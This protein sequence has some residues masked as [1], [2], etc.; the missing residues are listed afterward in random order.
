M[1]RFRG[2]DINN[3]RQQMDD[4]LNDFFGPAPGRKGAS[5]SGEQERSQAM[6]LNVVETDDDVTIV[7]PL[8]G[9]GPECV[10]VSIRGQ[11]V[12]IRGRRSDVFPDGTHYYRREWG[13]GPFHR[14]FELP[15]PIDPE[16]SQATVHRGVLRLTIAK[17]S[18]APAV[19]ASVEPTPDVEA[20]ETET[21]ETTLPV[22]AEPIQLEIIAVEPEETP[23]P[24]ETEEPASETAAAGDAPTEE[25]AEAEPARKPRATR[26]PRRRTR[27]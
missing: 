11:M 3:L 21:V 18:A 8:P 7:T 1:D 20:V 19:D 15:M 10:E 6:P 25:T 23:A 27:Y 26:T 2:F 9:A 4:L 22:E 13:Y 14:N 12:M 17:A 24:E 16:R 5:G